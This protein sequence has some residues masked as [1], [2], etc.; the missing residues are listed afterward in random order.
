MGARPYNPTFGRFLS[1]D[2][3][4]GGSAN[5]Y[6]YVA[7][8]PTNNTDLN[9]TYQQFACGCGGGGFMP[10]GGF[11]VSTGLR[12]AAT[13]A[14][15]V[16]ILPVVSATLDKLEQGVE[17][18]RTRHNRF[19]GAVKAN[20]KYTK[21]GRE[22]AAERNI[23]DDMIENATKTGRAT[24]SRN[25]TVRYRGRKIWVVL[26]RNGEVVSTGWNKSGR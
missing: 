11:G 1:V 19:V 16:A 13:A 17:R 23:S 3:V 5:D 4:E 20:V 8:D 26:N 18:N 7:G 9:G 10:F 25:S 24:K 12:A 15:V 22:Q 6:D 21:H 14:A 2:P